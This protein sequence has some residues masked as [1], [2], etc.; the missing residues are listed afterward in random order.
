MVARYW[1]EILWIAGIWHQVN[2]NNTY[3]I[4]GVRPIGEEKNV[5]AMY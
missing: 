3:H 2:M 5:Y 4:L 1:T